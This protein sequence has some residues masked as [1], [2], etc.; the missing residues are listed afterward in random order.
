MA[1]LELN[2]NSSN[3]TDPPQ[4]VNWEEKAQAQGWRPK[5][6]FD[7]NEEDFVDAKEFVQR[8]PLFEKIESQSRQLKDINKALTALKTH[9]TKVNEA[10]YDRALAQLERQRSEAVDVGNGAEF[11]RIDKQIKKTEAE[12]QALERDVAPATGSQ[13]D[14]QEFVEWQGKNT[15]YQKDEDLREYADAIGRKLA[16]QGMSPKD[17]LAEVTVKVKKNFPNKFTNQ[18]KANA[19]D[20]SV[21][22]GRG[23]SGSNTDPA[24]ASMS[25]EEKGIMNT[26]VKGGHV[27]KEQ[28]IKDWKAINSRYG[29]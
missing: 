11:S 6:E 7:G 24:V 29:R 9:Y 1:E 12:K 26:L 28:Y 27:T 8:K 19:P 18:N 2:T 13:P 25:D 20:V 10:A 21:S 17:V 16:E 14:P 5:D 4:E 3:N 15:W 23:G 22:S